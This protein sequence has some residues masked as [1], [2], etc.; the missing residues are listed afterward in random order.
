MNGNLVEN[1]TCCLCKTAL[2]AGSFD[3]NSNFTKR[4]NKL[5]CSYL[6]DIVHHNI[7]FRNSI[8]CTN[9]KRLLDDLDVAEACFKKLRDT[10]WNY[11]E[12]TEPLKLNTYT[13]TDSFDD[14]TG[15]QP[16]VKLEEDFQCTICSKSFASSHRVEMHYIKVH[17]TKTENTNTEKTTKENVGS[18]ECEKI[19]GMLKPY[20]C[21]VCPK[22]WKTLGELRNHTSSH[23]NER[24][25][26]CEICGQSY[27]QKSALNV[28]V[29]MHN[30]IYPFTCIYCE[31]TFTQKGAL[32]RHLPLHT[33]DTPYQCDVCGKRFVHHTS[34]NIHKLSHTGQKDYKCSQCSLAL[35]SA[36]HLKRHM[37]VHTGEK[38]YVC[39][40]CDKRFAERYNLVS[41]QKLHQETIS[42]STLKRNHRCPFCAQTFNRRLKLDEHLVQ[43][44]QKIIN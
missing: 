37:R 43:D 42:D 30:G 15:V 13:Q 24:P 3:L 40:L 25:F 44:H 41:H 23:S 8:I 20:R 7:V 21:T 12:Y 29:G 18:E 22:T 38:K 26:V 27:K 36:S 2:F 39:K 6:S 17:G 11:L 33:G 14:N 35:L 28:H 5:L 1:E 31:K 4:S 34:F 32:Q 19:K 10:V 16:L 9:C